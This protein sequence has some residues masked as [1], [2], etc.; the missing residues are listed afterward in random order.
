MSAK[1]WCVLVLLV[2]LI[3]IFFSGFIVGRALWKYK[4]DSMVI[5]YKTEQRIVEERAKTTQLAWEAALKKAVADAEKKGK[6][7]EKAAIAARTELD[8]LRKLLSS[9]DGGM[10]GT[11]RDA[12]SIDPAA[13][14]AI[15]AECSE[16]YAKMAEVADGHARDVSMLMSAWPGRRLH[17]SSKNN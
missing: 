13:T 7:N 12:R 5:E 1:I 2:F 16:Q 3:G 6:E 8:R 10:S 4:F 11:T 14:R 17:D 9:S 15:L